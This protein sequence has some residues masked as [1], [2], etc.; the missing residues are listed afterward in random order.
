MLPVGQHRREGM[1]GSEGRSKQRPY[2]RICGCASLCGE[3][4]AYARKLRRGEPGK[5]RLK[6]RGFNHLRI[7]APGLKRLTLPPMLPVGRHRREG[8]RGSEGRSKQ[9]PYRRTCG[10]AW[11]CGELAPPT[12]GSFGAANQVKLMSWMEAATYKDSRLSHRL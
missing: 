3:L 7:K 6:A 12:P 1:R 11:L 10:R 8:M 9:R 4:A 5:L 2:R